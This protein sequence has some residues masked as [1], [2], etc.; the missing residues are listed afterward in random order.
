MHHISYKYCLLLCSGRY[1]CVL[2]FKNINVPWGNQSLCNQGVVHLNE[3]LGNQYPVVDHLLCAQIA[4]HFS[5]AR[6]LCTLRDSQVSLEITSL[7]WYLACAPWLPH[8]RGNTVIRPRRRGTRNMESAFLL[9]M[10]RNAHPLNGNMKGLGWLLLLLL[11]LLLLWL[12]LLL[13]LLLLLLLLLC[14][15]SG[16]CSCSCSGSCSCSCSCSCSGSCS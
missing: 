10:L 9:E 4:V 5:A 6:K 1:P 14:S 3:Y 8:S 12:W 13:W 16:S 7:N 15:G 11:L 2:I